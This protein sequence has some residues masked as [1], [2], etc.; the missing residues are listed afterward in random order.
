M[1]ISVDQ[2]RVAQSTWAEAVTAQELDKLLALYSKSAVLKPTLSSRIR[3]STATIQE[4]FVGS[5]ES[6]DT[7][8]LKNGFTSVKFTESE[9][10]LKG[11]FAIDTGKY[12]FTKPDG[13]VVK[14]DFTF[15]YTLE[16]G[17]VRI[18]TQHSS[19]MIEES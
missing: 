13:G 19:L 9:P 7:G 4:Y 6:G 8:F 15:C 11:E 16:S 14:A 18:Q 3:R 2:V 17:D 1:N 10:L 12:E 5:A